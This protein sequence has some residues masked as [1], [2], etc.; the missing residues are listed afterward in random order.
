MYSCV[1]L[2]AV[3]SRLLGYLF[4]HV[5]AWCWSAAQTHR[6]IKLAIPLLRLPCVS[7]CLSVCRGS[8]WG[9][10]F[11]LRGREI[12]GENGAV[13]QAGGWRTDRRTEQEG[14]GQGLS[15]EAWQLPQQGARRTTLAGPSCP[16]IPEGEISQENQHVG[17]WSSFLCVGVCADQ[18]S[19]LYSTAKHPLVEQWL[20]LSLCGVFFL[21]AETCFVLL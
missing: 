20:L 1:F 2:S 10:L 6:S 8:W 5:P 14:V 11:Q 4:V 3:G 9:Q 12:F 16:R 13:W 21:T 19:K 18:H 7:I 17:E 15:A